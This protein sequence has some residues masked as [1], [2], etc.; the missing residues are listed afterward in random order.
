MED[1]LLD[2]AIAEYPDLGPDISF[3]K[4]S[5]IDAT[6]REPLI[7]EVSGPPDSRPGHLLGRAIPVV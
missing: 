4:G 5:I 3:L 6:F 2:Y 1:Y 7:F